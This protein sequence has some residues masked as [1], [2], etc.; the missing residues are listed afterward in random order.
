M[1]PPSPEEQRALVEHSVYTADKARPR[2]QAKASGL[3]GP[4]SIGF[5]RE[6][7]LF[8][9]QETEPSDPENEHKWAAIE[10]T[11]LGDAIEKAV[12]LDHPEWRFPNL[13]G[14]SFPVQ[15]H[16]GASLNCNP[17]IIATDWNAVIDIKTKNGLGEPGK[18][19]WPQGYDYQTWLYVKGAVQNGLLDG[20]R[21]LW[22]ILW[23]IDRA[24]DR[25]FWVLPTVKEWTPLNEDPICE[26]IDDVIYA[27]RHNERASQDI[28]APVC[29]MICEH[30]GNCRGTLPAE[31][32]RLITEPYYLEAIE[33]YEEAR[34][35]AQDA[36]ALRKA[37][38]L[39][40]L[41]QTGTTGTYQVRTTEIPESL[42]P[43]NPRRSSTRVEV[44]KLRTRGKA[45]M[46]ASLPQET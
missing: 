46:A 43:A 10:G 38:R 3:I 25:D 13:E 39:R 30:F 18:D 42:D 29:A 17:D 1:K 9:L 41:G 34:Q 24:D 31:E 23:Y 44:R 6:H 5:C 26:W 8:T 33:W 28:P 14:L 2:A 12:R 4:S 21:P 22:Q 7:A 32:M 36:E 40:L 11:V 45:A 16:N 27:A 20:T 15:L 35:A 37:A 19:P